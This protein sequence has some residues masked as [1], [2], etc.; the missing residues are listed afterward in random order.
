MA[1]MWTRVALLAALGTA[2][3]ALSLGHPVAAGQKEEKKSIKEIMQAAHK[4]ADAQ[5]TLVTAAIKDGKWEDAQKSA[6]ELAD[7]G[8][9]LPKAT[10]KRGDAAS[11]EERSKKYAETTKALYDATV[12]KDATTSKASLDTLNGSCMGCHN[13]H[14]GKGK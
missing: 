8:A 14:K 7:N 3:V 13:N 2:A 1:Q 5:K 11:W 6:K 4:G 9:L 10:P 12:K